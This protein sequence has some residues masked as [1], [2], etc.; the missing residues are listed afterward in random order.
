ML[1]ALMNTP[2]GCVITRENSLK[3]AKF[4]LEKVKLAVEAAKETDYRVSVRWST[5]VV[6]ECVNTIERSDED[7]GDGDLCWAEEA[8]R[9][10]TAYAWCDAMGGRDF[11]KEVANYLRELFPTFPEAK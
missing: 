5:D 8:D 10:V 9:A 3:L 4:A 7:Y 2:D 11:L 1:W 6:E